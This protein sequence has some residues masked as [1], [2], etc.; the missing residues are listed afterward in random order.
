MLRVK[1]YR[2]EALAGMHTTAGALA[3][4]TGLVEP[5]ALMICQRECHSILEEIRTL[6]IEPLP[7]QAATVRLA[8]RLEALQKSFD[9]LAA[10]GTEV[11]TAR[12]PAPKP[13]N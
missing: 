11:P 12:N 7:S 4:L 6:G 10:T 13:P 8:A 1:E 9:R 3:R 2:D 5:A